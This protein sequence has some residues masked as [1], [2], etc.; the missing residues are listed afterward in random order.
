[1]TDTNVPTITRHSVI[2]IAVVVASAAL[3]WLRDI[4]TPLALAVFLTIMVDSFVRVLHERA[5]MPK[6]FALPSAIVFSLI[7]FGGSIYVIADNGAAFITQ[8]LGYGPRL[9]ETIG[10]AAALFGMAVPP[11][12]G[13]LLQ[14][15]DPGRYVAP[16]LQ[17]LQGFAANALF[18][19]VYMGFMFASRQGFRRKM[20][21]LFPNH[22]ARNEAVHVFERIRNSVEQYLWIQTVTGLIIGVGSW[23]VMAMLQLENAVFFAFLIFIICYI[24]VVGG[25]VAIFLPPL[26]ALMQFPSFAP[27]IILLA[28]LGTINF[29]VGNI[30]LPRMQGETLNMDPIVVLLSLALWT[31][32]WG[33]PGAFLS[34]PLTGTAMI[35]LAQFPRSR[36]MAVLLSGNGDPLADGRQDRGASEEKRS[37]KTRPAGR[38]EETTRSSQ[39]RDSAGVKPKSRSPI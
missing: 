30:L 18:V 19:M 27:A 36:W 29:V 5:R 13:Q 23:V 26:Y 38:S 22:D 16:V 35:I 39:K 15:L 3:Y 24:P 20:V 7:L 4:L 10:K 9:T 32:I 31:A 21:A 37:E 8:L 6:R 28:S 33:L 11:T 34:T 25:A 17:G 2:I 1:M 14:Q 12:M